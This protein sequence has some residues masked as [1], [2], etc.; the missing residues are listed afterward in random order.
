MTG[1]LVYS[2]NDAVASELLTKGRDLG[3][4]VAVALLGPGASS[5]AEARQAYGAETV[6]VVEDERLSSLQP[7]VVAGALAAV[8]E[9]AGASLLLLG[10]TRRGKELAGRVA[11][12]LGCGAVT[13]AIGLAI[14]DGAVTTQRYALGG[15]TVACE[16]VMTDR[17]VVACLPRAFEALPSAVAGAVRVLQPTLAEAR[18]R[19]VERRPKPA[20]TAD[21]ESAEKLIAVGKGI[22][23]RE[24][25]RIAEELASVLGAE[26]GCTRA[27]A[28]DYHWL[29]EDRIIGISGKIAKPKLLVSLGVSG[30]IQH[31]VGIL[32]AKVIVAINK[33]KSAPI[34][35]IADYGIVADLYEAVPRLTARLRSGL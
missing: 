17:Q 32:G 16:R 4:P 11:Q 20:A 15:N 34:F 25:L 2:E 12:R 21:V 24:D 7:D 9:E 27:L 31:A 8:A 28:A 6:F 1:V 23:K 5:R 22:A 35:R 19:V 3:M 30:Q 13:D 14:V 10:S 26:I 33:D 18:A 29:G